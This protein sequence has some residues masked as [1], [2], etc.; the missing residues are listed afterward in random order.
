[1]ANYFELK[2]ARSGKDG[3]TYWTR[4]GVMF[5]WQSGEGFN[6]SFEALP[7]PAL[8]DN[9]ELEVRVVAMEPYDKDRQGGGSQRQQGSQREGVRRPLSDNPD[10][11]QQGPNTGGGLDDDIPF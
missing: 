9:G 3:K 7:L 11:A 1:M 10:P 4:V 8:N 6:L 2:T 5:P